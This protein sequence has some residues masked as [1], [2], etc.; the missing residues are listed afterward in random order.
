MPTHSLKNRLLRIAWQVCWFLLFRTSP[1]P[2]FAWRRLL[3]CIFGAKI[4][5]GSHFY[6]SA[7]VWAPWNLECGKVV[8]VADGVCIYNTSLVEIRDLA[9]VSQG[10]YL[11]CG[12]HDYKSLTFEFVS[13]PI[14][15]GSEAWIAAR[16]I[17]LMGVRIGEGAVVG[18]GS[19]VSKDVA[20]WTVV[21]GN[22]AKYIKSYERV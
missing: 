12:S 20:P 15:V 1:R 22:P 8:A 13:K 18:A 9:I 21:S 19:V 17:V 14:T 3:L 4:G 16:A 2:C 6:P 11:C 7:T 5:E 10:A